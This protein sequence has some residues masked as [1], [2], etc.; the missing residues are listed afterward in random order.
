MVYNFFVLHILR[1]S[2]IISEDECAVSHRI[3]LSDGPFR[4]LRFVAMDDGNLARRTCAATCIP[5]LRDQRHRLSIVSCSWRCTFLVSLAAL[6]ER[7]SAKATLITLRSSGACLTTP[8]QQSNY[9]LPSMSLCEPGE[10][11]AGLCAD[12]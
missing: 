4:N 7:F 11:P 8:D 9:P 2:H 6:R 1:H 5:K 10:L 3:E 12:V